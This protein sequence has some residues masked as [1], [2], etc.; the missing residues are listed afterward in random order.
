MRYALGLLLVLTA[1]GCSGPSNMGT[2][3]GTV[4]LDGRPLAHAVVFFQPEQGRPSS[5]ITDSSGS[6]YLM[7]TNKIEGALVGRH[8]VHIRTEMDAMED[9]PAV[10]EYLPDRYHENSELKAE[11]K[12]GA[13]E[14]DFDL[15][16]S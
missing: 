13:N 9:R 12:S 7:Y 6:Y 8:I 15:S 3:K 11:V 4:T 16:S 1:A 5:A 2:V 10:K 14:I